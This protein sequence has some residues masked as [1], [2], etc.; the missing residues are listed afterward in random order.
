MRAVTTGEEIWAAGSREAAK[1]KRGADGSPL[2]VASTTNQDRKNQ[3]V[4]GIYDGLVVGVW[5]GGGFGAGPGDG[6]IGSDG[7]IGCGPIGLGVS[8][9][10]RRS[11]PKRVRKR[12]MELS[13]K[14]SLGSGQ[15]SSVCLVGGMAHETTIQ[16][17]ACAHQRADANRQASLRPMVV[18]VGYRQ[19]RAQRHQENM[20]AV[21]PPHS[22][23]TVKG[24][25]P[26]RRRC[27][28]KKQTQARFAHCPKDTMCYA[29][30]VY[31]HSSCR[32]IFL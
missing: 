9:S 13:H 24:V 14:A 3:C 31:S 1:W 7:S 2:L 18:G 12:F 20:P 28:Q 19:A 6:Q 4:K 5:A 17:G 29:A 25:S 10:S 15:Q 16:R 27:Q 23:Q 30:C 26:W 32:A 11:T 8:R 22:H 21:K